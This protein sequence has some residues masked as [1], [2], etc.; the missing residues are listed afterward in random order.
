METDYP[1][2]G[3]VTV[4]VVETPGGPWSL[5][6]RVP[7]WSRASTITTGTADAASVPAGS[8]WE[9]GPRVWRAGE[10]VVLE[11]DLRPRVTVPDPRIDAVRGCVAIERGPLVYCLE[12]ADLPAGVDLE[13]VRLAAD[14]E[15]APVPRQD[16]GP[17]I[18]G[19][20]LPAVRRTFD[21]PAAPAGHSDISGDGAGR[22]GHAIEVRSIP[23]FAWANRSVEA[24]RVWIPLDTDRDGGAA[25]T[26]TGRGPSP[27]PSTGGRSTSA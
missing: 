21:R 3:R 11:L 14:V 1:W 27:G 6:L 4:R 26:E 2:A 15:P 25:V 5:A 12:T 22:D 20:D 9:S 17:T 7:A 24:M 8:R 19:L 13:E 18:V 16:L 23:Y 10:T